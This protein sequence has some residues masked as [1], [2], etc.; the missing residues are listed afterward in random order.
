MVMCPGQRGWD[1]DTFIFANYIMPYSQ[2]KFVTLYRDIIV[3]KPS[4]DLKQGIFY[5][6]IENYAIKVGKKKF[7]NS[8]L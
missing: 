2:L 1:G 3:Q 4:L 7:E 6:G 8:D 5:Q